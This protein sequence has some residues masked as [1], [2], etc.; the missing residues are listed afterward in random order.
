MPIQNQTCE[1]C[2]QCCTTQ[3]IPINLTDIFT[4]STHLNTTPERFVQKYLKLTDHGGEKTYIINQNPCPFLKDNLCSIHEIKPTACKITPCPKNPKYNKIK[5]TYG[6]TTLN[7][8]INSKKDMLA[9]FIAEEHTGHYLKSHR[10]FRQSTAEKY[11]EQIE[12]DLKNKLLT[13][14]LLRNIIKLS[15]HPK[16]QSQ[17][18][19]QDN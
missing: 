19:K 17:I 18:T 5:K 7:F 9:H 1:K 3:K 8:L 16:Y 13:Q 11:K 14:I 4:I 2:G 15:I 6:T 10:K 12:K